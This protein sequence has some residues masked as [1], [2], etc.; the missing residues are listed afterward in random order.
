MLKSDGVIS[1]SISFATIDMLTDA[2]DRTSEMIQQMHA[3]I[4]RPFPNSV[5]IQTNT[6]AILAVDIGGEDEATQAL[7]KLVCCQIM[8]L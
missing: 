2:P 8:K 3:S 1:E 5:L 4:C 6:A 7:A